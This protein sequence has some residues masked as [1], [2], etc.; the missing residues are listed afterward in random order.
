M[1][2]LQ[3]AFRAYATPEAAPS[4]VCAKLNAF[5]SGNVAPGRF[6]TFFYAI[7]GAGRRTFIYENAGHC[8]ALLLHAAGSRDTRGTRCGS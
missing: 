4:A 6:I 5:I 8:P 3:P 1:A 7:L 2:S